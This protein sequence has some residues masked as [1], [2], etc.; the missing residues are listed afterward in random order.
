M[1]ERKAGSQHA[2]DADDLRQRRAR[3][4]WARRQGGICGGCGRTLAPDETIWWA[5]LVVGPDY[6]AGQVS[7]LVPVGAECVPAG[8]S[9]TTEGQELEH[10]I[11]CGRGVQYPSRRRQRQACCSE[12]CRERATKEAGAKEKTQ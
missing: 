12:R 2:D 3:F 5:R 11:G 7:R 10:C 9:S 4:L 6:I 8:T 1:S